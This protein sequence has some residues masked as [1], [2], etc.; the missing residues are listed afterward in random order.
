MRSLLSVSPTAAVSSRP[1]NADFDIVAIDPG[2]DAEEVAR[3]LRARDDVEYA[4]PAYFMHAMIVPNDP[5]YKTLQWNLPLIDIERAWDIQPQ[6]GSAMTVAVIDTGV[7]YTA[8]TITTDILTFRD[9]SGPI[10]LDSV[11]NP[12]KCLMLIHESRNTIDDGDFWWTGW[13][14]VDFIHYDGSTV[15]YP[16][17]HAVWKNNKQLKADMQ[18]N[19]WWPIPPKP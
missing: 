19:L 9:A 17:G 15:A 16:D 5:L 13:N 14:D 18:L 2:E 1:A 10:L 7:A 3:S 6:A 12:T 4:Q 8:A 11:V